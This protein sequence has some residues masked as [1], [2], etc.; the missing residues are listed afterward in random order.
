MN[1][2]IFFLS[3]MPRSGTT[4]LSSILSQNKDIFAT[5]NSALCQIMW[6]TQSSIYG[7]EQFQGYPNFTGATAILNSMASNYYSG[8]K[9]KFIIDKCRDWGIPDNLSMIERYITDEPKFI[10]VVRDV[11]EVLTSFLTLVHN[12]EGSNNFIDANI[13]VENP[14][15]DD[16]CD[17]L[18]QP[19]GMIDRCLWSI[20]SLLE[21]GHRVH[22]ITYNDIV[23]KKEETVQGIYD[24]LEIPQYK[25]DFNN[26][27]NKYPENDLL[28]G[29]V[30]FHAVRKSVEK[31]S[32]P[33][34][35]VL[36][37]YVINKYGNENVWGTK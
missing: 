18:M 33:V 5:P 10:V 17:F 7:T 20:K 8:Y 1:K 16:R 4:V 35:E 31:V 28:F 22:L 32:K 29:L 9:E 2:E 13:S 6:D 36:S 26:I 24:F 21:S 37:D 12:N 3:G 14:T 30:G 11:L 15:D 19:N 27:I 23:D 25:H 34:T